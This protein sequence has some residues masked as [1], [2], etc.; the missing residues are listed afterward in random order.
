MHDALAAPGDVNGDGLHDLWAREASTGVLW[1]YSGNGAGGFASRANVGNGWGM[2]DVLTPTADVTGDGRPDL[3]GRAKATGARY[4]YPVSAAG[5][6]R[7]PRSG[8][9]G[10]NMHNV[11]L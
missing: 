6:P 4:L 9:S 5:V 2:H 11:V 1:F 10:W 3:F 7:S 8:G